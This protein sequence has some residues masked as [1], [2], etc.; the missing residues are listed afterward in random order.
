[1]NRAAHCRRRFHKGNPPRQQLHEDKQHFCDYTSQPAIS[2]LS[3][4]RWPAGRPVLKS[5]F[6]SLQ[7]NAG[8]GNA[9]GLVYRQR[10]RVSLHIV[11]A[12]QPV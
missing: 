2:G 5:Q 10:Q 1:M 3:Q 4:T 6:D 12:S 9:L 11:P 8:F 7:R